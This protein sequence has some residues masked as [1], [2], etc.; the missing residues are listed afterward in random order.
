MLELIQR[1]MGR[2]IDA[3]IIWLHGLGADGHDFESIGDE[4]SLPS[5]LGIRFILP[6]APV[7]PVSIN[8]GMRMRAWYDIAHMDLGQ[9]PDV[10]GIRINAQHVRELIVSQI[11]AGIDPQ[12][13]LLAGFSQGGVLALHLGMQGEF[14]LGGVIAL[15]TYGPTLSSVLND[16]AAKRPPVWMGHG[17]MDP[18][19][20]MPL[21]KQAC[22]EM[23]QHGVDVQ[24]HE[25]PMPHS[26]CMPEIEAM[27]SF[28]IERLER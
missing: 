20:P 5:D 24:W 22:Q 17:T 10:E 11:Q 18:V 23:L 26:V 7:M 16:N 27:G 2:Q 12:R 21:G 6:H 4:M 28:V 25:Y 13:I 1:E 8:G 3:A 15:S 14:D 9:E 19:V